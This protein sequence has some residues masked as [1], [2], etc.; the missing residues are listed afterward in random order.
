MRIQAAH[1]MRQPSQRGGAVAEGHRGR[2]HRLVPWLEDAR[3]DE[4]DV[5]V[6]SRCSGWPGQG[7]SAI[8]A[9]AAGDR[10]GLSR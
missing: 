9:L 4:D 10:D 6:R 3:G 7:I 1:T 8:A 5:L 2:L